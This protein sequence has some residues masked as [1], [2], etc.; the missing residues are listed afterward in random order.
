[1]K[2]KIIIVNQNDKI[3]GFKYREILE[4]KDIYRVSALWIVNSSNEILLAKR[5]KNKIHDPEKWGPAV[6]GTVEKGETYKNN[7]IKESNEELGLKN[8]KPKKIGP[9]TKNN[10]NNPHFTQWYLLKIDKNINEFKIQQDEVEEIKWFKPNEL[11]QNL[12]TNPENFIPNME[13]YF[14]LFS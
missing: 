11:K 7:I 1:M 9:K 8:I 3:I 13:K 10:I 14:E 6:A 5:N 2:P 4:K 12:K